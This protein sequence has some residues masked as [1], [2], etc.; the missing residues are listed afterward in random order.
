MNLNNFIIRPKRQYVER[1]KNRERWNNLSGEA[2][3]DLVHHVAGLPT[4]SEKEDITAKLFDNTCLKL[5]LGLLNVSPSYLSLQKQVRDIASELEEK[6]GIPMVKAQMQLILEVQTDEYWEGI[7]LPLLEILR[8]RLRDLIQF[9][10]K[11]RMV[12]YTIIQDEMGTGIDTPIYGLDV[13]IDTVRYKKKVEAFIRSQ[14]DHIVIRKLRYN[15]SL[16][17]LD[18]QELERFLFE[19]NEVQ[20]REQFE[21][22]FGRQE[23]LSLFIRSLVGLDR[24][25]A[26]K[27]FA[28]YLDTTQ[29]NANQIR[30]IEMIIEHLTQKGTMDAGM[31][32]EQ[33]FTEMHYEGVEGV[34]EDAV[35]GEI[36]GVIR[37]INANAES[38]S[39]A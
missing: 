1:Y 18:L 33:P 23:Q 25:A 5:Q 29:F 37:T 21:A 39:V 8:R 12:V 30:F 10:E 19:S 35:V 9:I 34:F 38:G 13:G 24:G 17:P 2:M 22:A 6:S 11:K 28:R 20:S 7:T 16:T 32:Y 27:A 31:L 26:K 14:N 4:E 36:I 3:S 15:E